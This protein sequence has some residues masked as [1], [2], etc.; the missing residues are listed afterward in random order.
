MHLQAKS[1]GR[2]AWLW[3]GPHRTGLP[4][5]P[6][7]SMSHA[8]MLTLRDEIDEILAAQGVTAASRE[9]VVRDTDQDRLRA[10]DRA[11]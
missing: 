2:G 10:L 5:G 9:A 11:S 8:A 7:E 4:D 3:L 1:T 6:G